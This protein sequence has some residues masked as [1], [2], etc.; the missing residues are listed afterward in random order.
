MSD[1]MLTARQRVHSRGHKVQRPEIDRSAKRYFVYR[2]LDAEG[3][4]VYIGRSCNVAARIRAHHSDAVH[5]YAEANV[6]AR[7]SWIF[8]VRAV[9]MVGPFTWDEAV[10]IERDQIERQ[11]PRGNRDLTARDHRPAIARRSA[12]RAER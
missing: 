4:P 11:Q 9:D 8:D 6:G 12:A 2:L 10:R 1:Y 3:S 7:K 5:P